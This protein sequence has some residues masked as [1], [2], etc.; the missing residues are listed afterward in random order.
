MRRI[1]LIDP[2]RDRA[3]ERILDETSA[4]LRRLPIGALT[5]VE[6]AGRRA[7]STRPTSLL[8][9]DLGGARLRARGLASR[10]VAGS[11]PRTTAATILSTPRPRAGLAG[12]A[13]P[14]PDPAPAEF[15]LAGFGSHPLFTGLRDGAC[16]RRGTTRG[17][18]IDALLH[19]RSAAGR[20]GRRGR[21][22]ART[23]RSTRPTGARVGVAVGAGG[24]LCLAFDPALRRRRPPARGR[25][26]AGQCA[27]G[28]RHSA[29]RAGRSRRTVA[30]AGPARGA[31]ADTRTPLLDA[32]QPTRGRHLASAARSHAGVR[33]DA[34]RPPHAVE[35]A[36]GRR[37]PGRLGAALPRDARDA[38]VRRRDPLRPGPPG[39]RRGGRRARDRWASAAG[40]LGRGGGRHRSWCGTSAV[41]RRL[42]LVAEWEVDL[43]RSWPYPE[44]AYGDLEV[45][46]VVR[47]AQSRH[48][49][50]GRAARDASRSGRSARGGRGPRPRGGP[51][52]VPGCHAAPDRGGRGCGSPRSSSG[53]SGSSSG[54]GVREVAAGAGPKG[55]TAPTLRHGLRGAG[56]AARARVRLG[57]TARRRGADRSAGRRAVDARRLSA[58]LRATTPGAS[59]PAPA[60]P[61]RHSSSRAPGIPAR[62]LLK[63]LAQA[64]HPGG[65]I[66][67]SYPLG[68]LASLAEPRGTRA[69]LELAERLLAWTG[70]VDGVRR[71]GES[72]AHALA[73]L[74]EVRG[75]GAKRAGAR[76]ARE[77]G[78][79]CRLGGHRGTPAKGR[80]R[81]GPGRP[82]R[83]ARHRRGGGRGAAPGAGR[84]ARH[85][86]P[87]R[88]CSRRSPRSGDSSPTHPTA[89]LSVAPVAAD[90]MERLRAPA[91]PGRTEPAR[92]RGPA[93]AGGCRAAGRAPVRASPGADGRPAW[94]GGRVH[95]SGRR[96]ALRRRVRASRRTTGTRCGSTLRG[97]AF[98]PWSDRRASV[99]TECRSPVYASSPHQGFR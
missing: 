28:R 26:G 71:L 19:G 43:R 31:P 13:C 46:V 37:V 7:R 59:A 57:E 16:S 14:F 60:P 54:D 65:G 53:P 77:R 34:R 74:A 89:A 35:R 50:R 76:R 87:R 4:W 3:G 38:T 41:G 84:A 27:P 63:F 72:L 90:G 97:V 52:L 10:A 61:P 79:S 66:P 39:G 5:R 8:A 56:R 99:F 40:A 62:E 23:R 44:G 11:S 51:D 42:E 32:R 73:F 93:P 85:R 45:R 80:S 69:F 24:V 88:P 21:R 75:P 70:D 47:W 96:P 12:R 17:I 49:V 29:S 68:G 82:G 33:V 30:A 6:R 78:R 83:A 36:T 22:A 64:Q 91:A 2:P 20:C 58:R 81:R 18:R 95:R 92:P 86:A 15:G 67:A 25:G 94:R 48:R 98:R 1:A 9:P 55:G